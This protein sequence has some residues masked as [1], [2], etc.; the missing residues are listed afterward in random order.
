[1]PKQEEHN[2]RDQ[3]RGRA[4]ELRRQIEELVKNQETGGSDGDNAAAAEKKPLSPR[5]FIDK[6]MRELDQN[7]GGSQD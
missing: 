3:S 6:R 7:G 1:M 4:A 5:K 2:Q